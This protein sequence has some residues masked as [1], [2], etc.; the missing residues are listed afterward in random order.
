MVGVE[1]LV[2]GAR[3]KIDAFQWHTEYK[4]VILERVEEIGDVVQVPPATQSW[5][6]LAASHNFLPSVP[7]LVIRRQRHRGITAWTTLCFAE[8]SGA[9]VAHAVAMPVMK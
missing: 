4:D 7:C 2:C 3:P 1:L 6:V 5:S 8:W 9:I